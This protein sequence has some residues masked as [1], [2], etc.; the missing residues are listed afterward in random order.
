M[1]LQDFR[2]L[3]LMEHRSADHLHQ[4]CVPE[5][6]KTATEFQEK[7]LN[8][9]KEMKEIS[10][11]QTDKVTLSVAYQIFWKSFNY[12]QEVWH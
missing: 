1:S 7:S 3:K 5:I 11:M 9:F 6:I 2:T 8:A 12:F 10:K 4:T